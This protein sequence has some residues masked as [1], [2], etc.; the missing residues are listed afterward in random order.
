LFNI[1]ILLHE[2]SRQ[3]LNVLHHNI[4]KHS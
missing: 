1:I 3:I 4:D 2:I